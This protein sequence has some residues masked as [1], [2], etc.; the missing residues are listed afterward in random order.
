[1]KR[2]NSEK[3]P[4][5]KLNN[6]KASSNLVNKQTSNQE[7][8]S[9]KRSFNIVNNN[10]QRASKE[11]INRE[12]ID[13]IKIAKSSNS[14]NF[15]AVKKLKEDLKMI[16]DDSI[17]PMRGSSQLSRIKNLKEL[18]SSKWDRNYDSSNM[19][20]IEKKENELLYKPKIMLNKVPNNNITK[21][22]DNKKMNNKAVEGLNLNLKNGKPLSK[23]S[24]K[25]SKIKS[26]DPFAMGKKHK[27]N[28]GYVYSA[29]G[30]PCRIQHGSVRMRLKWD[31]EPESIFFL[32]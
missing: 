3:K 27:T 26:S 5:V 11:K 13:V 14:S 1:M 15:E 24:E 4:F 2:I 6:E 10:Y 32:N 19:I 22:F 23:P 28:F 25:Y 21:V 12:N 8:N 31:I 30:I 7:I 18:K 29:G 17:K 16:N 20:K 9:N